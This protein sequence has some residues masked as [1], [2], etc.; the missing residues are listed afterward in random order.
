MFAL[1]ISHSCSICHWHCIETRLGIGSIRIVNFPVCIQSLLAFDFALALA[2]TG[3]FLF[4]F[5]MSVLLVGMC[6]GSYIPVLAELPVLRT[7]LK[8]FLPLYFFSLSWQLELRTNRHMLFGSH[9]AITAPCMHTS[10]HIS[11]VARSK[12]HPM[13]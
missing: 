11:W 12:A 9:L 4:S 8:V 3:N 13:A 7:D 2:F 10:V 5:D 6:I 1:T